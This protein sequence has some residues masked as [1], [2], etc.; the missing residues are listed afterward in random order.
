VLKSKIN[1]NINITQNRINSNHD[2][3]ILKGNLKLVCRL[4]NLNENFNN[5]RFYI[6]LYIFE[7]KDN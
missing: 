4:Y 2:A 5:P 6:Y 1:D 3:S 7:Q